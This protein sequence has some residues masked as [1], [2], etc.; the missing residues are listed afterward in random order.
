MSQI[1]LPQTCDVNQPA[2]FQSIRD[3]KVESRINHIISTV[4][5][6]FKAHPVF[7]T[8]LTTLTLPILFVASLI[9]L[10]IGYYTI[11]EDEE[12]KLKN[13]LAL[14][15]LAFLKTLRKGVIE[16]TSVVNAP[17]FDVIA[18]TAVSIAAKKHPNFDKIFPN[19]TPAQKQGL[20]LMALELKTKEPYTSDEAHSTWKTLQ[21][22]NL[23]SIEEIQELY[24]SMGKKIPEDYYKWLVTTIIRSLQENLIDKKEISLESIKQGLIAEK[25]K[26]NEKHYWGP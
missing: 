9:A 2:S 8:V 15:R 24:K 25:S 14:E 19:L 13:L 26:L 16:R 5:G 1:S 3:E 4:K 18:K 12:A 17:E 20:I 22:D 23:E 11:I 10:P 21:E 7:M 6:V